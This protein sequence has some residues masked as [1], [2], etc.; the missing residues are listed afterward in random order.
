MVQILDQF[1]FGRQ[2]LPPFQV[3]VRG[4]GAPYMWTFDYVFNKTFTQKDIFIQVINPM[5]ESTMEGFNA[6]IFA[7]GMCARAH[8][9]G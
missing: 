8:T 4:D 7:Y 5:I 6:T 9:L 3:I 1:V 2:H